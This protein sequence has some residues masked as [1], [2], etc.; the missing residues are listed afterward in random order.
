MIFW[1]LS[2][3]CRGGDRLPPGPPGWLQHHTPCCP[4]MS[5]CAREKRWTL[6][7][8]DLLD[9]DPPACCAHGHL[10]MG[11][12]PSP[13]AQGC[14]GTGTGVSQKEQPQ[15]PASRRGSW[16]WPCSALLLVLVAAAIPS[17]LPAQLPEHPESSGPWME[18][19]VRLEPHNRRSRAPAGSF[20]EP[21]RA[22]RQSLSC[23]QG[24]SS[25]DEMITEPALRLPTGSQKVLFVTSCW[26]GHGVLLPLLFLARA[27]SQSERGSAPVRWT[28]DTPPRCGCIPGALAPAARGRA[29]G[30]MLSGCPHAAHAGWALYGPE[31]LLWGKESHGRARCWQ[32]QP[33]RGDIMGIWECGQRT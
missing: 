6:A 10:C 29:A 22:L 1:N 26:K 5:P 31:K 23:S 18:P 14:P 33:R 15:D 17:S 16:S 11:G 19:T 20:R 13:P 8:G 9:P 3:G 30:R 32:L 12:V 4:W 25:F 24:T 2:V 28:P 7:F 27:L 21:P